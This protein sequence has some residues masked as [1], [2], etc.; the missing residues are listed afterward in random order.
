MNLVAQVE[1]SLAASTLWR[2]CVHR[3]GYDYFIVITIWIFIVD[4]DCYHSSLHLVT[5]SYCVFVFEISTLNLLPQTSPYIELTSSEVLGLSLPLSPSAEVKDPGTTWAS[6]RNPRS[7]RPPSSTI[8]CENSLRGWC[9]DCLGR[10][11][12]SFERLEFL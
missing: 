7:G 9:L 11:A 2:L 3:V 12:G 1:C 10:D 4:Y 6:S 8:R 5:Y